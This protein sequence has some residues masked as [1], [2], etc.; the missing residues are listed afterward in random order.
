MNYNIDYSDASSRQEIIGIYSLYFYIVTTTS[1]AFEVGNLLIALLIYM[2]EEGRL[3]S[4]AMKVYEIKSF[5]YDYLIGIEYKEE[6]NLDEIAENLISKLQGAKPNGDPIKF[7]YYDHEI[8]ATKSVKIAYID[9]S[10]K[11]EGFKITDKGLE[12][13]ISSKEIPQEAKLTVALYL[14]KLQLEKKKY[15]AALNTIKNINLET[16][17]QLDVKNE[18]LSMNR[19]GRDEA[20]RLYQKYWGDFYELRSEESSH[21]EG[22]K[23]RLQLYK[24]SEYLENNN[25]KL[26]PEDIEVLK[27]IEIE[28]GKSSNLQAVYTNEISKMPVEMLEIDKSSMINIF[29]S[30]FNLKEHFE[31]LSK[32]DTPIE[33]F[34]NS[35]Q[36]L[37]LPKRNKRFGLT[38]A[39][40]GQKV[41]RQFDNIP[42]EE[43]N[44]KTQKHEDYE[45]LFEGRMKNNYLKLFELLIE[46]LTKID[47]EIED[48]SDFLV[49]VEQ[50]KGS[51]AISS[52]DFLSFLLS[53]S[54]LPDA[55]RENGFGT[56]NTQVIQLN[57]NRWIQNKPIEVFQ[58]Q[59]LLTFFWFDK[60]KMDYN[61]EIHVSTEPMKKI[62]INGDM[63]RTIGNIKIRLIEK[64]SL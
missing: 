40:A 15:R 21:Y 35:I 46:Y 26:T 39:L 28:L 49:Y 27:A 13:L 51:V 44:I 53:L 56:E 30:L 1:Y 59:E 60:L 41:S 3:N 24:E 31:E 38:T 17:R 55:Q 2:V 6:Y 7:E 25:I 29:L 8:R 33:A 5:I 64:G 32:V 4:Y 43:I 23:E 10:L 45:A 11:D 48:V 12:F 36:P 22:A 20:S 50:G 52:I 9:Y 58:V 63:D 54:Y 62:Q 47:S 57:E 61:A 37:L 19:Y 34:L 18:I 14:F 42:V 16:L